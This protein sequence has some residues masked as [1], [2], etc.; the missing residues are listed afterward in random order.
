MSIFSIPSIQ[1]RTEKYETKKVSKKDACFV[2]TYA[3]PTQLVPN[4]LD[5]II[6]KTKS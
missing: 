2:A 1:K 3:E 5:L 4:L 6:L